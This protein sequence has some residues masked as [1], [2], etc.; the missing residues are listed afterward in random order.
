MLSYLQSI[1]FIGTIM[2]YVSVFGLNEYFLKYIFVSHFYR[3]L[4]YIL[5]LITG[6]FIIYTL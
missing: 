6:I 5:I 4:Y 2:I 1:E 3:I